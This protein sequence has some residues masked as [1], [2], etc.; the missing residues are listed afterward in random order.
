MKE[1]TTKSEILKLAPESWK[2]EFINHI[3]WELL[4]LYKNFLE[5]NNEKGGFFSKSDALKILERHIYE[6]LIFTSRL[7]QERYVSRETYIADVG[8]GPGL[9][10]ILFAFFS[11]APDLHLI[12]SQK[13]KLSL[14]EEEV[15]R[16]KLQP[17]KSRVH[18]L[19]ARAEEIVGDFD[20]VTTRAMVPYPYV[21]EVVTNMLQTGGILC[22][23][24]GQNT[25]N[26]IQEGIVLANNGFSLKKEILLPELEFLGKRHIKILQKTMSPRKGYPREWK[27][28]VKESKAKHG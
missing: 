19:Y 13:R 16:G 5:E 17:L 8:T 3:D 20:V 2:K 9:P 26:T 1:N 28:I 27:E 12:D 15:V 4:D 7:L 6:S 21:A 14:L 23:F 22:P 11:N 18:F 24:L 10:G 25:V